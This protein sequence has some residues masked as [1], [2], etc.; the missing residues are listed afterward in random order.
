MKLATLGKSLLPAAIT[1]LVFAPVLL[2]A[3]RSRPEPVRE[4]PT[5]LTPGTWP[6]FG[7]TA[8]RNMVN[9]FDRPGRPVDPLDADGRQR[10]A[11]PD[12][13]IAFVRDREVNFALYH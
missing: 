11:V 12:D 6:R 3:S 10:R 2:V 1:L 4:D 13:G 9:P 8:H 7:G 5:Q